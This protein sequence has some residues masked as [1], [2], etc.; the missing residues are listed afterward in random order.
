MKLSPLQVARYQYQPKLPGMLRNGIAAICVKD[1]A[2]TESAADQEKIKALLQPLK[3]IDLQPLIAAL[4]RLHEAIQ[5]I[6]KKLFSGLEWAWHNLF[7]PMA[8]WTAEK[9]LPVFL[10]TLTDALKALAQVIEDLKPSFMWLWENY[11]KP[12][13][14]WKGDHAVADAEE[15]TFAWLDNAVRKKFG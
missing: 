3:D 5:P 7:V 1:G 2:P 6:S 14:Q 9:L 4:G 10:D 11:L 13:A 15:Y 8:K 12:L